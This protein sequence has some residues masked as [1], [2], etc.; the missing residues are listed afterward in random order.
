[1][2]TARPLLMIPGPIEVSPEVRDACGGPPPGHL[3]PVV[4]DAFSGSLKKMR[5]V[6]MADDSAQPFVVGGAGTVAMDMAATNLIAP[7][8][9]VVVVVTGYFSDRAAEMLRRV[10]ASQKN[11]G[12]LSDEI[13]FSLTFH[14]TRWSDDEGGRVSSCGRYCWA[15]QRLSGRWQRRRT[16]RQ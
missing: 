6:W 9:K 7:G 14:Q 11:D 8:D 1:M 3:A 4:M 5:Q 2:S 16:G 10:G 13:R 15:G 12:P